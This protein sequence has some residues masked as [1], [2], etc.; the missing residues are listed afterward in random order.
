M[1]LRYI[2]VVCVIIIILLIFKIVTSKCDLSE[3]KG[4][5]WIYESEDEMLTYI[6]PNFVKD[7]EYIPIAKFTTWLTKPLE[8]SVEI[9]LKISKN[10]NGIEKTG[11]PG[12]NLF[13]KS[14]GSE[15][16]KLCIIK[17]L[18]GLVLNQ[19]I[20]KC[21]T[22]NFKNIPPWQ[23]DR[24]FYVQNLKTWYFPKYRFSININTKKNWIVECGRNEF[25][26]REQGWTQGFICCGFPDGAKDFSGNS[27]ALEKLNI[28]EEDGNRWLLPAEEP[29]PLKAIKYGD[30]NF[31]VS[32]SNEIASSKMNLF[33]GTSIT[34]ILSDGIKSSLRLIKPYLV[35]Y[36]ST[37][38]TKYFS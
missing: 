28:W 16:D 22:P 37:V 4:I 6:S 13:G 30:L 18:N 14:T 21:N 23:I 26:G 19:R 27:L 15:E 8:N 20:G 35:P 1:D 34:K 32:E 36:R 10:R 29:A 12:M 5:Y 3:A 38:N 2:V 25:E 11:T 33:A 17:S 7:V 31:L 24:F 9:N